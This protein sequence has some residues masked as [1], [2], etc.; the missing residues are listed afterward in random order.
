MSHV[1]A[2]TAAAEADTTGAAGKAVFWLLGLILVGYAVAL[3]VRVL[4]ASTTWID[5]W[6]WPRTSC[7]AAGWSYPSRG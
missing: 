3:V 6:G 1:E 5:G 2:R 4:G 7:C